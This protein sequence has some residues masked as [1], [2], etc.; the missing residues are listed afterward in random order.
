MSNDNTPQ[1]DV[2]DISTLNA[3][4]APQREYRIDMEKVQTFEDLKSVFELLDLRL[5]IEPDTEGGKAILT[6]AGGAFL[7]EVQ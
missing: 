5:V 1:I 6:S 3:P 7:S 4:A 2:L